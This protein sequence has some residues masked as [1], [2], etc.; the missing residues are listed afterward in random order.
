[1][2]EAH[3][4]PPV[5][6]TL[7]AD[8]PEVLAATRLRNYGS[9]RIIYGGKSFRENAFAFVDSNFFQVFTLPFIQGN[10]KTALTEP[11]SIV[12]SREVARKFFGKADPMGKVLYFKDYN[13]SLKITGVIDQVPAN[14]HF[15]FDIFAS[16]ASF[17]RPKLRPG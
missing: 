8:Y 10:P 2:E 15:H 11:N 5:A 14:S 13:T 1:M 9:P 17:P 7:R 3:V 12:I 4:M 16:M 6:Q